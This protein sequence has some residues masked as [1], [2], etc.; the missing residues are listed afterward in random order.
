MSQLITL[1]DIGSNWQCGS[2]NRI[3]LQST[4]FSI[5]LGTMVS[6][7]NI[8]SFTEAPYYLVESLA[9]RNPVITVNGWFDRTQPHAS[10]ETNNHVDYFF[11]KA[12]NE[13]P[14]NKELII[15]DEVLTTPPSGGWTA[16]TGSTFIS[17][18]SSFIVQ[19]NG[20]TITS[21][22]RSET[23]VRYKLTLIVQSGADYYG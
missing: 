17:T 10:G 15:G 19:A 1:G 22:A 8:P 16:N 18:G 14:T 7:P 20:Y 2:G 9:S 13:S 21:P 11:L 5:A 4:S 3:D 12:F 6:E 23:D